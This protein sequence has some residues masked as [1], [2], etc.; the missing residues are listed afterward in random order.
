[1]RPPRI[2]PGGPLIL[3]IGPEG[4]FGCDPGKETGHG[5]SAASSRGIRPG[6]LRAR[7]A[8]AG[9]PVGLLRRFVPAVLPRGGAY[10]RDE[11][12]GRRLR[13]RRREPPRGLDRGPER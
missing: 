10:A 12:P 3:F 13:R 6:L 7:A 9:R 1:M 5:R 4:E 8:T 2:L 11:R